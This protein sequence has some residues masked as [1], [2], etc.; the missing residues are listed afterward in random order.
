[1]IVLLAGGGITPTKNHVDG[2][3]MKDINNGHRHLRS[4]L[5]SH[6]EYTMYFGTTTQ[7]YNDTIM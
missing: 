1:M 7:F 5:S 2:A 3:E 6:F 4:P